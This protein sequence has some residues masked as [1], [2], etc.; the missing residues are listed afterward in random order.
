M[1]SAISANNNAEV[2]EFTATH[3]K[4]ETCLLNMPSNLS[5]SG[6]CARFLDFKTLVT[7]RI[8]RL[9]MSGEANLIL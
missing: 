3:S 8:S 9:P 6:P 5:T 4:S 2:P 1:P 7:A